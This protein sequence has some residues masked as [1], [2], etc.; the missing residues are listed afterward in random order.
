MDVFEAIAMR[1]SVRA[2]LPQP[3]HA[4]VMQRMKQALRS[5]PSACNIQP[6]HFVFVTDEDLRQRMAQASNGQLW[7]AGGLSCHA[8]LESSS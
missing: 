4:R 1:R 2:Y 3:I 5:A 8:G 6:W 7:M